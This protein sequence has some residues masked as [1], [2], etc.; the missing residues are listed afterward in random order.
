MFDGT[1]LPLI[2]SFVA[3]GALATLAALWANPRLIATLETEPAR[4][5]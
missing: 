4:P 1:T 2:A 5:A 3:C